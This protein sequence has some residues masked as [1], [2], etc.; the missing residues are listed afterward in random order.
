MAFAL[1]KLVDN[2]PLTLFRPIQLLSLVM[3]VFVLQDWLT[4][5]AGQVALTGN[6][7][8][9]VTPLELPVTQA[10]HR[11]TVEEIRTPLQRIAVHNAYD[12]TQQPDLVKQK[13]GFPPNFVHSLD[14]CHMMLTSLFCQKQGITFASVHD[15]FWTHAADVDVMNK[16]R[17]L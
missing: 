9:W 15:S 5:A 4:V 10:Y 11:E 13:G 17:C 2:C 6:C 1:R 12:T 8:D 3:F 7:V 16:V 14:S